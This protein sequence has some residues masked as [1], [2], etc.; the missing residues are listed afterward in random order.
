[1]K[2]A[3]AGIGYVGL[4]NAI[5]LAQHHDV[6]ALDVLPEKVEA[7]NAGQSPI[8]DPE[9]SVYLAT[10]KLNLIA[11][12]DPETAYAGADFIVVAAPTTIR[13]G[14]RL[15]CSARPSRRN[16]GENRMAAWP[17]FRRMDS[18]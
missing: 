17:Y 11:T 9:A 14:Y 13:E 2:I 8:E 4:S 1:M 16:S 12:L 15:S 6:V 3:V 10:K 18:V 7:L 5:L